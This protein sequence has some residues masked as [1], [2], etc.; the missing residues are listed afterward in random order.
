MCVPGWPLSL[1]RGRGREEEEGAH[2]LV[3]SAAPEWTE[4]LTELSAGAEWAVNTGPWGPRLGFSDGFLLQQRT[5]WGESRS[6]CLWRGAGHIHP[7]GVRPAAG[8]RRGRW[9]FQG[10]FTNPWLLSQSPHFRVEEKNKLCSTCP[11]TKAKWLNGGNEQRDQGVERSATCLR[12]EWEPETV[13][14]VPAENEPPLLQHKLATGL[15]AGSLRAARV[16]QA[17]RWLGAAH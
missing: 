2:S 9:S 5:S 3:S 4:V 15:R 13:N 7:T 14:T 17:G 11:A 6:H 8:G 12:L 16:R 10:P 1:G